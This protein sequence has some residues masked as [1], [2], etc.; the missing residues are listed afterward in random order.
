MMS[1]A[2][3][4]VH[5]RRPRSASPSE[6]RHTRSRASRGRLRVPEGVEESEFAIFE[7][8]TEAIEFRAETDS[9]PHA[10]FIERRSRQ[11]PFCFPV[12]LVTERYV[13]H[14]HADSLFVE[15]SPLVLRCSERLQSLY[16]GNT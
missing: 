10:Q 9:G 5:A 11:L 6:S 7:P 14:R 12:S 1:I 8:S 16:I 13:L 2:A 15:R 3:R 4:E